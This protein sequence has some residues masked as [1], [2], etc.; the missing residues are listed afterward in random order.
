MVLRTYP[1]V[2]D[3]DEYVQYTSIVVNPM[4]G[5]CKILGENARADKKYTK[6]QW[7]KNDNNNQI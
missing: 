2:S 5:F 7:L 3:S 1:H 6:K 4:T